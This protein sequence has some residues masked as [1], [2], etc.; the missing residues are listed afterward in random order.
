MKIS[1]KREQ[2]Q[3]SLSFAEREKFRPQVKQAKLWLLATILTIC[4]MTMVS[5]F[6]RSKKISVDVPVAPDYQ[7]FTQWYITNRQAAADIFYIISTE[8]GDYSLPNGEICHYA[9]TYSDSLRAPLYGEMLGVDTLVSGRLNFFS[10]YYRQCSLQ[11]FQSDSLASA[12]MPLALDDVRRAFQYYLEH[13][14]GGRP[15]VLAGFSQGAHIMLELLKE[16]DDDTFKRMIAAYAIGVTITDDDPHIVPAKRA[17]D[18]G[19]TICYNS[20]RDTGCA[21]PGWINS[22]IAINPVN[23]RTDSTHAL[24]VTEPSPLL[25]VSEQKK[26]TMTVH[27]DTAS[28]LLVV[29]GYT[30][31]DYMLPLLGVEGNYHTREIWLYRDQLRENIAFRASRMITSSNLVRTATER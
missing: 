6:S 5:C 26:D 31:Q 10:P 19:V 3:T 21:M 15:F 14:N 7:D 30:A 11:T 13:K 22:S 29:D 23:W 27:L 24:L 9:D 20:V 1:I 17:D 8:T 12:R 4:G 2:S 25:P 28:G 18:T 16:M